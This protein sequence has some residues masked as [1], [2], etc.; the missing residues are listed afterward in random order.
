MSLIKHISADGAVTS[1]SP[2]DSHAYYLACSVKAGD[3]SGFDTM[4]SELRIIDLKID[5]D[6][7]LTDSICVA[8]D[9]QQIKSIS[10]GKMSKGIDTYPLGL[11]A[12][13]N[14]NGSI[15]LYDPNAL[16]QKT[17][18]DKIVEIQKHQ[19]SINS[20][21]FNPHQPLLASGGAD[22]NIFISDLNIP[23]Q[24][25]VYSPGES[26]I[27]ISKGAITC[28]AW[29]SKAAHIL[30]NGTDNGVVTVWDLRAKTPWCELRDVR[31]SPVSDIA[32]NPSEG[33][34]LIT[35]SDDDS[36]P[37][38]KFYDLRTSVNTPLLELQGHTKGVLSI[39]WSPFETSYLI[40][41]GKDNKT[42][43]WDLHT[44]QQIYE[45]PAYRPANTSSISDPFTSAFT[46]RRYHVEWSPCIPSLL[47][48]CSMDRSIQVHS[49]NGI[50]SET[51]HT[52]PNWLKRPCG[53]SFGFGGKLTYFTN[54]IDEKNL[55]L[56]CV[57]IIKT[58]S[59]VSLK[60]KDE[61]FEAAYEQ[62]KLSAYCQEKH[63]N[64]TDKNERDIWYFINVYILLIIIEFIPKI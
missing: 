3:S 35:A 44:G 57:K 24:P 18:T 59:D 11:I 39:T 40:S 64:A 58:P 1:W 31:G 16:I 46:G 37:V 32:W 23:N 38:I 34:H 50:A 55:P 36:K 7:L 62:S 19:G 48:S 25:S 61:K 30:G 49:V 20:L 6:D 26:N 22:T 27:N 47:S 60:E 14:N 56:R 54:S 41:C 9:N 33:L 4:G 28:L 52:A 2:Y 5:N 42:I 12:T 53:V 43:L 63:D 45:V 13:G 29:N 15:K 51:S 17:S 21:E 10:W 8:K